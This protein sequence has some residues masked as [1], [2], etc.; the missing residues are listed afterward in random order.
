MPTLADQ[1][2]RPDAFTA[3]VTRMRAAVDARAGAGPSRRATPAVLD[4]G[5]RYALLGGGKRV[6]PLLALAA[7]EAILGPSPRRAGSPCRRPARSS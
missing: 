6:R 7:A 1:A 5:L 4:A 3:W 2:A